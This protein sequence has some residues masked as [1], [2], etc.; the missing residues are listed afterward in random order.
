MQI[1]PHVLSCFK[2]SNTRLLELQCSNRL[3]NPINLT[4][5]SLLLKSTSSTST[6]SPLQAEIQHFCGDDT[7]KNTAQNA[8]KRATSSENFHFF[9]GRRA[10]I[11]YSSPPPPPHQAFQICTCVPEFQPYLRHCMQVTERNL[12]VAESV[13]Q[14]YRGVCVLFVQQYD[15]D[16]STDT[17]RR[18]SISL[19]DSRTSSKHAAG[20]VTD[21]SI[22]A[23]SRC[24]GRAGA[25]YSTDTA[26]ISI[27]PPT[28]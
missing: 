14:D 5:N 21:R 17:E 10:P 22:A 11:P 13:R 18:A 19:V 27:H 2:I 20:S 15:D 1:V 16:I 23:W 25:R 26:I 12:A 6:K 3:T 8:P 7:D 9:L 24:H 4:E 28:W